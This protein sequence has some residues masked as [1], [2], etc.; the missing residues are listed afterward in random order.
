M[1]V[2]LLTEQHLE[3]RSLK[4]GCAGLSVYTCQNVA[5]LE[6]SWVKLNEFLHDIK[7]MVFLWALIV[8]PWSLIY[9]SF[10]MRGTF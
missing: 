1:S 3:F 10:V 5:L 9:S 4:G 6:M 7:E 8:L 2:K